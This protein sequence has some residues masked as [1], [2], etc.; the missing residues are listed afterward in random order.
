MLTQVLKSF[1]VI[2]SPQPSAIAPYALA[3][4]TATSIQV[5]VNG[6]FSPALT[7]GVAASAPGIFQIAAGQAAALN[8]DATVNGVSNPVQPSSIVVFYGTGEG[9]VVPAAPDGSFAT[10]ALIPRPLQPVTVTVGTVPGCQ[11]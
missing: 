2:S 6:V 7:L 11:F 10:G 1:G 8:E 9:Q 5:E 4:K 3:C